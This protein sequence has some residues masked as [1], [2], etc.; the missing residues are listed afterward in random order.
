MSGEEILTIFVKIETAV[1]ITGNHQD[2]QMIVFSGHAKS[3]YF[4][5][6]IL[7][8]GVDLQRID[9][10]GTARLSARYI[11]SGTDC[12][13]QACRL[14]IENNGVSEAGKKLRTKPEIV[15]DSDALSWL[16][17]AE[18]VGEIEGGEELVIHI[19]RD[20]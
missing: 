6:E 8:P 12:E 20:S 1:P 7:S 10:D 15:T 18:L 11:L 17:T 4:E 5:G 13:G 14:F 16:E 3:R 9:K 19:R 2:V